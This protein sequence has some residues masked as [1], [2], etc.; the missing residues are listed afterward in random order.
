MNEKAYGHLLKNG[1]FGYSYNQIVAGNGKGTS[2]FIILEVNPRFEEIFSAASHDLIGKRYSDTKNKSL[3]ELLQFQDH[4]AEVVKSRKTFLVEYECGTEGKWYQIQVDSCETGYFSMVL[5]EIPV[6]RIEKSDPGFSYLE[7]IQK[8]KDSRFLNELSIQLAEHQSDTTLIPDVLN[9]IKKHTNAVFASFSMYYPETRILENQVL[10]TDSHLLKKIV[11][12]L[13]EGVNK[14][15]FILDDYI[16]EYMTSRTVEVSDSITQLTFGAIPPFA[17]K[18]I[19]SLTGIRNYIGIAH[20]IE[21]KLFGATTLGFK[22]YNA[23]PDSKLLESYAYLTA[24]SMRRD[25]AERKLRESEEKFRSYIEF[26]P[27]AVIVVD[28]TGRYIEVNP[29][30]CSITGY[31]ED[32]LLNIRISD[33]LAPDSTEAGMNHFKKVVKDGYSVGEVEFI[34]KDGV[35]RWWKVSAKRISEKKYIGLCEDTTEAREYEKK[36]NAARKKA[37]EGEK[38]FRAIADSSPLAI[39]VSNGCDLKVEYVNPA[40]LNLFGYSIEEV[41][42]LSYWWPLAYPEE[43][44]RHEVMEEWNRKTSKAILKSGSIEPMETIVRCKDGSYKNIEWRFVS[45]GMENWTMGMDLTG[46]RKAESEL[47]HAR[48]KAEESNRLKSAFL[49]NMSHEIRTPMN[50]ILGFLD[51]MKDIDLSDEKRNIYID[52]INRSGQRLLDTINDIIEIS[53]IELGQL[54]VSLG[55]TNTEEILKFQLEFFEQQAK[56]KNISL[57]ID[58]LLTGRKS[59][60]L[61]DHHKIEGML[62]NLIKNALKFTTEGSIT[63]GNFLQNNQLIFYV[64][65]TG[66]GIPRDKIDKVFERFVQA[67]MNASRPYDGSGLGLSIVK[68]YAD[69]LGGKIW[70]ESQPG[71]GSIFYFSIPYAPV[72]G[73]LSN[74]VSNCPPDI[75]FLK[76]KTILV[77]EDDD[78]S[79][80]YLQDILSS[81]GLTILRSTTGADAVKKVRETESLSLVLMDI[82]MPVMSGIEATVE[83]RKFNKNIPV[84]AQTAFA[85][86]GD[87][88]LIISA[89]CNDYLAKPVRREKLFELIRRVMV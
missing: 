28:E 61:S 87:R 29:A 86:A 2:D 12:I 11:S 10:L 69:I 65:D 75:G 83:I 20:L 9:S 15:R 85:M 6:N 59:V 84:I 48:D 54:H 32:E 70:V 23:L 68:A 31:S 16:Y 72:E 55:E 30:T 41:P 35:R 17:D 88:E 27:H 36:I 44:Y 76:G 3:I 33:I 39:N 56:A 5:M 73:E 78:T 43:Q 80:N 50:G 13:G 8:E 79:Y 77:A 38:K 26:A 14:T 57:S 49:A 71:A 67:D 64:K 25:Q 89:G 62:T 19:S 53:K 18:T 7:M 1:V 66:M 40:F 22:G 42:E 81:E 21:G 63:F 45:T 58:E 74:E 46:F 60:I 34:R 47:I 82:M 51:L 4:F 24:L 37:E 52:I